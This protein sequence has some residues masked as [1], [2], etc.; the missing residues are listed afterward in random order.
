MTAKDGPATAKDGPATAKDGPAT[1]KDGPATAKGGPATAVDDDEAIELWRQTLGGFQ[2]AAK[3]LR[4][5]IRDALDLSASEAETLLALRRHPGGRAGMKALAEA[6]AY[7]SGGFTKL[8]DRMSGRGFV[9]REHDENDRRNVVLVLSPAGAETAEELATVAAGT[10]RA[11]FVDVI[12]P[13]RAVEVAAAMGALQRV[14]H[15]PPGRGDEWGRRA[16]GS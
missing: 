13:E 8:A 5:S 7:S 10:I 11:A 9:T 3:L 1:A 16:P 15:L 4:E 6:T 14:N 2:S 12:G